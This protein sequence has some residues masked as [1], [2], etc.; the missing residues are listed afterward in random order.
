M[1]NSL[2]TLKLLRYNGRAVF[3]PENKRSQKLLFSSVKQRLLL[4]FL[5]FLPLF[6]LQAQTTI[7]AKN[8]GNWGDAST[9][10]NGVPTAAD[11]VII[12]DN[13]QVTLNTTGACANLTINSLGTLT[14]NSNTLEI[15]KNGGDNK[16]L[17]VNGTL[18]LSGTT[19]LNLNGNVVFNTSS[20]FNMSGGN[21]NIDGNDGISQATSVAT[22]THLFDI[23]NN[24]TANVSGGIITFID[25]PFAGSTSMTLH[26][27]GTINMNWTGNTMN[28][29][30]G[31]STTAGP[32][33]GFNVNT[34]DGTGYLVL[35][36]VNINDGNNIATRIVTGP[37]AAEPTSD[38]FNIGGNLTISANS[39]LRQLV[40]NGAKLTVG[41]NLINNG[42]LTTFAFLEFSAGNDPSI[43]PQTLSG[44][45]TFRQGTASPV[46]SNF[47]K[48]IINNT[49]P[50]GLTIAVNNLV[51]KNQL[52][53]ING[54]VY[55]GNNNLIFGDQGF[56]GGTGTLGT[57]NMIVLGTG[58]VKKIVNNSFTGV[59]TASFTYPVGKVNS[60]TNILEYSPV[61]LT[62]TANNTIRTIG[63]KIK[64]SKHPSM[65]L[66]GTQ[67]D[68][69][70]RYWIFSD[71]QA[72]VGTYSYNVATFKYPSTDVQGTEA[73]IKLNRWNGTKWTQYTS[74]AASNTLSIPTSPILNQTTAPLG[75]SDFTGRVSPPETYYW[76]GTTTDYA[77]ATNWTPDRNTPASNDILIFNNGVSNTVTN[78]STETIGKLSVSNNTTVLL[79]SSTTR[80][81]TI[82]GETGDDLEIMSGSTLNLNSGSLTLA[83]SAGTTGTIEGTL[84][85][86]TTANIFNATN[87]TIT[88]TGTG[89]INNGG[90]ITATATTLLLNS[91][92]IYNHTRNGGTVP[93]LGFDANSNVNITGI[94]N[95]GPFLPSSVGNFNW[96]C[97]SQTSAI[98][99]TSGFNT[100]NGNFTVTSTGSTGSIVLPVTLTVNGDL[101][102]T[103]GTINLRSTTGASTLNLKK[104]LNQTGGTITET[105]TG[106][107]KIV[108]NG[109]TLQAINLSGT[110][111]N[112]I[113]YEVN[114]AAGIT[115]SSNMQVNDG[116]TLTLTS[117]LLKLGNFDLTIGGTGNISAPAPSS[118]SMVVINGTGQLKK[119]FAAS[120]TTNFTFPI[121]EENGTAE[122][123]PVSLNLTN[124]ATVRTIG[125][126]VSNSTPPNL[127]SGS[128]ATDYLNRYW[129]FTDNQTGNDT[130]SYTG[131]FEYLP[132][133]VVTSDA[134]MKASR[135]DGSTWTQT[136]S[137]AASNVLSITA[138]LTETTGPLNGS[139]FTGRTTSSGTYVWD[140]SESTDWF[141]PYNWDQ[142]SLPGISDN[143]IINNAF[144]NQP[145]IS[146][147]GGPVAINNLDLTAGSLTLN[148]GSEITVGG[149]FTYTSPA[150][151]NFDC[152]STFTYASTNAQTIYALNYGNLISTGSAAR[153]LA[154]GTI[155]ICGNFSPGT[156]TYSNS[157]NTI[158]FNGSSP[159]TIPAF[160]YNNLT[161]SSTGNRTLSGV[162]KIA[163]NF[164][165]GA[166]TYDVTGSTVE[167]NGAGAQT[168]PAFSYNNLSSS[169][170]GNR[171]LPNSGTVQIAGTF[172][173]GTETFHTF[174][175]TVEFNGT[176]TFS[177]PVLTNANYNNLIISGAG[178]YSFGGNMTVE[179]DYTQTNGTVNVSNGAVNNT[180]NFAGNLNLSG[181]TFRLISASN[182]TGAT[183]N[184]GT[185]ALPKNLNISGNGSINMESLGSTNGVALLVITGDLNSNTTATNALDFGTGN[186]TNNEVQLAGNLNMSGTGKFNITTT[187]TYGPKGL[188]LN[189][190]G[191]QILNSAVVYNEAQ[192]TVN[193]GSTVKLGSNF[194]VAGTIISGFGRTRIVVAGT[195]DMAGYTMS[196]DGSNNAA[197]VI[198]AGGLLT[199]GNAAINGFASATIDWGGTIDL[200]TS[201]YT[202]IGNPNGNNGVY[203]NGTLKTAK[204]EGL[205][206]STTTALVD[207]GLNTFGAGSTIEYN[208]SGAQTITA[209]SDYQNLIISGN[210]GGANITLPAGIV[211]VA[212]TF[213]PS[214]TNVTWATT[215]NTLDFTGTTQTIPVFPYN[216][217][218]I[219]GSGTKTLDGNIT[220]PGNL[221]MN[222]SILET[223]ANQINLSASATLTETSSSYITGNV[224]TAD[225]DMNTAGSA[226]TFNGIGLALSPQGTNLPGLTSVRRVT[227]S[228]ISA[229][230]NQGIGRYYEITAA[231]NANLDVT[232]VFGYQDH[233]VGSL[234]EADLTLYKSAN[235]SALWVNQGF[236][237]RDLNANTVTLTGVTGFSVWTLGDLNAPLPVELVWFEAKKVGTDAELTWTTASEYNSQGFEIQVSTNGKEFRKIGFMESHNGNSMQQYR[238]TDVENGKSGIRY[239]RLKQIDFDGKVTYSASKTVRFEAEKLKISVYPNPFQ[240]EI[241]MAIHAR[242]TGNASLKLRELTGKTVMEQDVIV[243][244]GNNKITIGL[245]TKMPAGVYFLQVQFGSEL[246]TTRLLKN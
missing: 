196:A 17:T 227:G 73:N 119:S 96:N 125:V 182:A 111:I 52:E 210:R 24:I 20:T 91:G 216:D 59:K 152:N 45:G 79:Q 154:N 90:S 208:G 15:G 16:T 170:G 200:G 123:S 236:T 234:S 118:A 68:Y 55:L 109:N 204:A 175:S 237:S 121:G 168:I 81:L 157:G 184:I 65:D 39:E 164:M 174:G 105:S 163:G 48:M 213:N 40:V 193:A 101:N 165:P 113:N 138:A 144:V 231:N 85:V 19:T 139:I 86:A 3:Y 235:G 171:T 104:D 87:A 159:Q 112:Q 150:T 26:Y 167:F 244:K 218:T 25:P 14:C 63:V 209:R 67:T 134:N 240:H 12:P 62:F 71:D 186:V 74:S 223:G 230:G 50:G 145:V 114:N 199:T 161:S 27:N 207:P 205:S 42:T 158:E 8:S 229:N 151:T 191:I 156:N 220:I 202:G 28:F 214:A 187:S 66:G 53:F 129:T 225:I 228:P 221:T 141:D 135:Y 21:F 153:T 75:G 166:N 238:F 217:L 176:G 77:L 106:T 137:G 211:G 146:I 5:S 242:E 201:Q 110:V 233:E 46:V 107:P 97:T 102:Q 246:I 243:Q 245:D 190:T 30:N 155:F 239:Y 122:Y 49:N 148:S 33:N 18:S 29:G 100:I 160:E 84:T 89:I 80:T 44:T 117:G 133:D 179:G 180:I 126:S 54:L 93:A 219:S 57:T 32:T 51:I 64:D 197:I 70:N 82:G 124:G 195:L 58:E 103:S 76:K 224:K 36:D 99:I 61:T 41:G 142:N 178:P 127:N 173:P 198:N 34:K 143:V 6:N 43:N 212:A 98:S 128:T 1:Q 31:I 169:G 172:S 9:W 226:Y 35:G 38:A 120:A 140:G 116:A 13:Q 69:L 72:G 37:T 95:S 194:N 115:L 60:A 7:T 189:G 94:T 130:Y 136:V 78:V 108:F 147:S 188:V 10:D 4:L 22:G 11:N 47:H 222:G 83:F 23:P 241:N 215:G 2:Q 185:T 131:N 88:V 232:M 203:I 183:V 206:G 181:G 149:T 192:L 132:A 177:I 162:V 56:I 92:A